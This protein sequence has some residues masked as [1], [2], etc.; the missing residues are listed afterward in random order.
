MTQLEVAYRYH[1]PPTEATVRAL[2]SVREVYGV[3]RIS[4]NEAECIVR[5]EFD[6]SRFK[7]PVI[8]GLLR[9]TGLDLC[10]QMVPT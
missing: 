2:D 7:E 10:E 1:T 4:F 6:A 8:A 5:V 3:R 9:E